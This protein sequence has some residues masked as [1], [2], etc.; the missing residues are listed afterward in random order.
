MDRKH[1]KL[2]EDKT[3]YMIIGNRGIIRMNGLQSLTV[4]GKTVGVADDVKNLDIIIDKHLAFNGQ[5][6]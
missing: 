2:N 6:N 1:L 5:I 4:N 3:E